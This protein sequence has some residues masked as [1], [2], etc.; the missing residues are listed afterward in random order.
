MRTLERNKQ[1]FYYALFDSDV[2]ATDPEGNKTG[3]YI[4]RYKEP[5]KIRANISPAS[6]DV[7]RE[8]F[9]AM[10]EYDK[11][12]VTDDID[13]PIDENTVLFIDRPPKKK[14]DGT[15]LYDYIVKRVA[16]SLNTIS[17][18]VSKVDVQ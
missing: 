7:Q 17:F 5:I 11:V 18:A 13:C 4:A 3:E 10:G 9:G 15:L 8:P 16:K 12:I 1:T 6:G 14:E 2:P